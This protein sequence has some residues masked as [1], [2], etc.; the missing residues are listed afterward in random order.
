MSGLMRKPLLV[1]LLIG[2]LTLLGLASYQKLSVSLFP[3]TSKVSISARIPYQSYSSKQFVET[4][5]TELEAGL[6]SI[7][8]EQFPVEKV[9]STYGKDGVEYVVS[10]GWGGDQDAERTAIENKVYAIIDRFDPTIRE[11]TNIAAVVNSQGFFAVNFFSE[12]RK[13]DDLFKLLNPLVKPLSAIVKDASQV[14]LFNPTQ[15]E[16]TVELNPEKLAFHQVAITQIFGIIKDAL[17][18]YSGGGVAVGDNSYGINLTAKVATV[19]ELNAL[20]IAQNEQ[21]SVFL[22]DIAKVSEEISREGTMKFKTSNLDSII[23]FA[24]PRDGGNIK[25][26][27]EEIAAYLKN[28]AKDLP[29]DVHYKIVVNPAEFI[30]NSISSVIREVFAASFLAVL[31]LFLFIGGLRNVFTAAIE[32]PIS[33]I[34][35]FALMR[36]FGMNLNLI[37]LGGLALSAGMNVDAS[38]VVL[39]N[40]FRKIKGRENLSY[41]EKFRIVVGAV[42]EVKVP[43]LTSTLTS[44]IVFMPL[45]FTQ[46]ITNALL[47][48]LAKAV[49]FSH[50]ISAI[51]ALILVPTIRLHLIATGEAL[52]IRSPI[53]KTLGQ[54]EELYRRTL[55]EFLLSRRVQKIFLFSTVGVALVLGL[56]AVNGLKREIIGK[57]E[58]EWMVVSLESP[59]HQQKYIETELATVEQDLRELFGSEVL[60]TYTQMTSGGSSFVMLKMENRHKINKY[61]RAAE[62]RLKDTALITHHIDS[63]SPSELHLPLVSD[64]KVEIVGGSMVTRS[65]MARDIQTRLYEDQVFDSVSI[66]PNSLQEKSVEGLFEPSQNLQEIIPR[67]EI[68]QYLR[69]ATSGTYVQKLHGGGIDTPIYL[70]FPANRVNSV[71]SLASLPI[72][73]ENRLIPLG[74]ILKF[75]VSEFGYALFRENGLE[76]SVLFGEM[77]EKNHSRAGEGVNRARKIVDEMRERSLSKDGAKND[78]KVVIIEADPRAELNDAIGQ[79]G[80]AFV[81]SVGLILLILFFQFGDIFTASIAL[82]AI[83]LGLIGAMLSLTV[84][85]STLS[86]NSCLGAIL[87]NGIAVANSIILIDFIRRQVATTAS[88]LRGV[89]DASVV[90]LRPILITSLTTILGMLPIALGLGEGGNTLQPLGIS[91]CGGLL[92][93]T[94][95][96]IYSVPC[97]T[98]LQYQRGKSKTPTLQPE[99]FARLDQ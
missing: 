50:G 29:A 94:L 4:I 46:G 82:V 43:I 6:R 10:F 79:L 81:I 71:E 39:E 56:Y 72:G 66:T 57:P 53:E 99:S 26:M 55:E 28:M 45:V 60:D 58:S 89:V 75:K 62:E 2:A 24:T 15:K 49:I 51:V 85:N 64:Y 20:K 9:E 70:R 14:T 25:R 23:L 91:V 22:K 77:R 76:K 65:Q 67:S 17:L 95:L 44:L 5:G 41:D 35:S 84:F 61:I 34:I 32:I 3:V 69:T 19:S 73:F 47:G 8:S 31:V 90:R 97:L 1:Y 93:S 88:T 83:P 7:G 87:L 92:I 13:I 18:G 68:S 96:T 16:V 33:L 48:D 21:S 38:V 80:R 52:V 98:Y 11:N 42:N 40:I 86:L 37:S 30:D 63:W 12:T 78:A 36:L 59:V 27:S 74:S 54:I